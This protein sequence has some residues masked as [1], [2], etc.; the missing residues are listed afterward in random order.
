MSNLD[1]L[2]KIIAG[3]KSTWQEEAMW[4]SENESWLTDSFDI[5]LKVLET[6]KAKKMTQKELADRMKVTP[7]FV[8]KVVKGQENLSLE[9][10]GKLGQ[11]LGVKLIEVA[12]EES[13]SVQVTYNIEQA[14]EVL[15]LFRKEM[16][17]KATVQ[18]YVGLD[19]SQV[20]AKEEVLEYRM[21]A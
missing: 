10:I 17:T 16:F 4:R 19:A 13:K 20:Y 11:A 6:L 2:N 7:Q 14:Y 15:E 12:S 8:N 3:K 9:T 1:R 5:A 18:G 21:Q